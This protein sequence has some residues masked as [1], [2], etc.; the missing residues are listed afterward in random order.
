MRLV[1]EGKGCQEGWTIIDALIAILVIVVALTTLL[2]AYIQGEKNTIANRNYNN[3]VYIAQQSLEELK[4]YDGKAQMKTISPTPTT[5]P[6][7]GVV[8]SIQIASATVVS[9]NLDSRIYPFQ[10]TVSWPDNTV[11]PATNRS[12]KVASFYYSN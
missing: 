7:D 3:A 1:R 2:S 8:Y 6:M 9:E 11:K 4:Q 10:V 5:T 12:I